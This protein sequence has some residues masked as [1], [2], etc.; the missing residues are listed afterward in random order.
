[1][2]SKQP[3]EAEALARGAE[4]GVR[5]GSSIRGYSVRRGAR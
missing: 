1:M 5:A 3:K 2:I 4:G